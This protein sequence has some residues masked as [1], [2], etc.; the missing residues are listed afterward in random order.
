M[1]PSKFL[2]ACLRA[3][4]QNYVQEC[5]VCQQMK[6]ENFAPAGMLHQLPIPSKNWIDITIGSIEELPQTL[7]Y[8]AVMVVV[9]R[10]LK[11]A[12][13]LPL[14]HPYTVVTVG[15]L[16]LIKSSNLMV[17]R[18]LLFVIETL[19]LSASFDESCSNC[20]ALTLSTALFITPK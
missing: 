18:S 1:D 12:H 9:D 7:G 8:D 10:L 17:C 19:L 11:Y 14:S 6:Q 5:E 2:L 3:F 20:R 13:F 4:V 16:F 15:H